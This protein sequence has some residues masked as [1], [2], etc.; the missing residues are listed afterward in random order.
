MNKL[1]PAKEAANKSSEARI[2]L[3]QQEAEKFFATEVGQSIIKLIDD[4]V[5]K[6]LNHVYIPHTIKVSDGLQSSLYNLGYQVHPPSWPTMD[7]S[8]VW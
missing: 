6:G 3:R 7:Y 4:A 1:Y 2:K 5:S 8:I